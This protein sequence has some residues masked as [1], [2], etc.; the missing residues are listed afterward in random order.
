[1]FGAPMHGLSF[2]PSDPAQ[3]THRR[4]FG[5]HLRGERA[6]QADPTGEPGY[7]V[8]CLHG[9]ASS[10]CVRSGRHLP[11][12]HGP[13]HQALDPSVGGAP[14][15]CSRSSTT[16]TAW[17]GSPWRD[18]GVRRAGADRRRVNADAMHAERVDGYNPL[19]VADASS[20]RRPALQG[21][22]PVLLDISHLSH[23]R[24]LPFG[25]VELPHKEE[26]EM[27]QHADGIVSFGEYLVSSGTRRPESSRRSGRGSRRGFAQRSSF[28]V[29]WRSLRGS[30][31]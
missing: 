2:A 18:H 31:P 11:F 16:S 5:D 10:A 14:P 23:L 19:A 15:C 30:R 9:D 4:R 17:A 12:R 13:V 28:L 22:G 25:R 20:G 21:K 1:M 26:V 24:P 29:P 6:V 7:D 27:W 8:L 3:K